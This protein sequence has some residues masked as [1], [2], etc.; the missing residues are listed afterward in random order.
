MYP[1]SSQGPADRAQILT[2]SA[3]GSLGAPAPGDAFGAALA[4]ADFDHDGYAD[5]A[6]GQ[7][8][9]DLPQGREG[10]A[11]TVFYG[12]AAG[13]DASRVV[14]L[15]VPKGHRA[16]ARFGT[17]LAA[18]DF[19]GDGYPDLAVGAPGDDVQRNPGHTWAASGTVR[20]FSGGKHGLSSSRYDK[21]R[22]TRGTGGSGFDVGFGAVLAV[23]DLSVDGL[24]DLVVGAPGHTYV[25]THGYGGWIDVCRGGH[26]KLG[27]C[28][29]PSM[30][31]AKAYAG[32]WAGMTSLAVGPLLRHT[33][34]IETPQIVIGSPQYA[35][36]QPGIVWI[37]TLGRS[38][39][40]VTDLFSFRQGHPAQIPGAGQPGSVHHRFGQSVAVGTFPNTSLPLL[41]VGA[42]GTDGAQGAVT[43]ILLESDDQGQFSYTTYTQQTPG[44]PGGAADGHEFGAS[45]AFADHDAAGDPELD[46]GAP[47]ADNNT[48]SLVRLSLTASF[49]LTDA[50]LL[51]PGLPLVGS[52]AGARFGETTNR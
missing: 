44:V 1:S 15:P 16:G 13:L 7:P 26:G 50:Q 37:V 4:S 45:V 42:P 47:G 11:V 46:V 43:T 29:R 3:A 34:D 23:G 5:L 18:A 39:R 19:D 12:S 32:N 35:D 8:G 10:G 28:R 36:D 25:G 9:R 33:P 38:T 30:P 49:H 22:G 14:D 20:V 6:V 24:A 31:H 41:A 21:K 51:R 48:G 27:T 2:R 17:A 52:A 40:S